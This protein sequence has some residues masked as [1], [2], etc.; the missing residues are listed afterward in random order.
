MG[1]DSR[2]AVQ[3]IAVPNPLYG[4]DYLLSSRHTYAR[5]GIRTASDIG[6]N[7]WIYGSESEVRKILYFSII[8]EYF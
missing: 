7:E 5:G 2:A 6:H 1:I 4:A 8:L 3:S